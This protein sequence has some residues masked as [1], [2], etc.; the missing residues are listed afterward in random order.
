[1]R[2]E[3]EMREMAMVTK[4]DAEPAKGEHHEK[5]G[6]LEPV[7]PEMPQINGDG[8]QGEKERPHQEAAGDPV[9]AIKGYSEIH[10]GALGRLA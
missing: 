3:R 7:E 8:G 10:F 5:Q 4:R 9:D 6:H 1:M 2:L